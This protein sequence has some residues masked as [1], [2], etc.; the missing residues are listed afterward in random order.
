MADANTV[1]RPQ[2]SRRWLKFLAGLFLLVVV[3]LAVAYGW[4]TSSS[5]FKGRILPS[6]GRALNASVTVSDAAIHP[7]SQITLHDLK[8]QA[9][10]QEPLVTVPQI[11][12]RYHLWDILHGNIRVDEITLVSPAIT[13][14]E[15]PD[16]SRNLDPILKALQAKPAEAAKPEP[17][18]PKAAKPLEVDIGKIT[19]SNAEFRQIKNYSGGQR[20]ISAIT[21]INFSLANVKNGQTA[22]LDLAAELLLAKNPPGGAA[23]SL[24]AGLRA[25][26]NVALSSDLKPGSAGGDASLSISQAAGTF[27]DFGGFSATVNC[28]VT[29]A[30]IK[31]LALRFQ[32]SGAALG[33]ISASGPFDAAKQEGKLH[34]A[35]RGID[36]RLLNLLG[37]R[38]GIDFG[39]T[40]VDTETEV[41]FAKA[42]AAITATGKFALSK[43]RVTRAGQTTPTLDFNANY[44]LALDRAAQTA[45]LRSL[46]LT[47]TQGGAP[48]LNAQLSSPMNLAWGGTATNLGDASFHLVLARLNLADWKPFLGSNPPAGDVGVNL[49]VSSHAGGQQI[50]F[51]VKSDIA[52]LAAQAG[53]NRISNASLKLS[54]QGEASQFKLVKL[55]ACKFE[56]ALQNQPAVTADASGTY[57]LGAGDADLQIKLQ[58]ALARLLQALPQPDMSVSSGEVTVTAHVTQKQ[59]TQAVAGELTLDNFSGQIGKNEFRNFGSKLNLDVANSPGRISFNKVSGSLS[60][61]GNS[62]GE[63]D[64]TGK[65]QPAEKSADVTVKFSNLNENALRPFLQPLLAG[66]T[67]VSVTLGGELS[68]QLQP[69]SGSAV[70]GQVQL[71]NLVV[72][73]PKKQGPAAAL[74]AGLQMD[75]ALNKQVADIRQLQIA[76]TP[77][78]RAKNELRLTGQLDLSDTNATQGSLALAA[79]SLDLTGYYDLFAGGTNAAAKAAPET[80]PVP[81]SAARAGEEPAPVQLPLRNF[82]LN[83]DIGKLYLHEVA[84]TDFK[85]TIKIDGGHV[86]AKPFQLVLNGAPVNAVADVDLG[87]AGYKYNVTFD[88]KS[89]PVAPL[90]N[91]FQ[92]A[93]AGQMGGSLTASAQIS[94]AGISGAGLQKNLA[95]QFD[96]DMTNL[97]LSVVNVQSRLLKTVINVVATIPEIVGNLNNPVNAVASLLGGAA[98]QGSLMNELQQSPIQFLSVRTTAGSGTVNLRQ[99]TVK[100]AAFEADAVGS[101]ALDSVL[102]NSTINIPVTVSLSQPIAKRL[103]LASSATN[104]A[105]SPLPQFLSLSGTLGNPKANINKLALAGTTIRA[106]GGS[107]LNPGTNNASPVQN[108]L[109]NFLKPGK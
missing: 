73:D 87:V 59:K 62:G 45:T 8:V 10:G 23:G 22:K 61:N 47:G 95:G 93:R 55:D 46:N 48:L 74:A 15:N 96:L 6:V 20:D 64:F 24:A 92:P 106:V 91:T 66:K 65:Y 39:G 107:L 9:A 35:M 101:I 94:G 67:L 18:S 12:L 103:N 50:S 78:S 52:N 28:D 57:D 54:A 100:S 29:P 83:A 36:R 49:Q 11:T 80:A 71:A 70:Q 13:L 81:G 77:T 63:F 90:V 109:N 56:L 69:Q 5:F 19:L 51:E 42:G 37:E 104:A 30:E 84:A 14:V 21:N 44:D 31:Q 58:A 98:G 38:S 16:G 7:F 76:L 26:F 34:V 3:L 68:A 75:V 25:N 79:D 102:T 72:N 43:L 17:A 4:L 105:Y 88:A 40:A 33:E 85:T 2:K 27:S 1:S 82:T 32:K 108:L 97:N 60:Q 99:A 86:V 89:V 53:S 41:E